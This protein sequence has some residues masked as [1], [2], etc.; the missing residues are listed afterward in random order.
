MFK[1]R[2]LKCY[3]RNVLVL[4]GT[5]FEYLTHK[6]LF[7]IGCPMLGR[8]LPCSR[9]EWWVVCHN[10]ISLIMPFGLL[11]LQDVGYSRIQPKGKHLWQLC[12]PNLCPQISWMCLEIHQN[13][14]TTFL[15]YRFWEE[16]TVTLKI[17][18]HQWPDWPWQYFHMN[19]ERFIYI[20]LHTGDLTC[21]LN[22]QNPL[23][24]M[25]VGIWILQEIFILHDDQESRHPDYNDWIHDTLHLLVRRLH[26]SL[27]GLL[28]WYCAIYSGLCNS[29]EDEIY[30]HQ[31]FKCIAE[32]WL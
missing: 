26:M 10:C 13:L 17:S 21:T 23:K 18:L 22:H 25:I 4:L 27:P 1:Q 8:T 9:Q 12:N 2:T 14:L 3:W 7:E 30:V 28:T 20:V 15:R 16:M 6:G 31:I 11:T 29:L 5:R 19:Q 32:T 24:C